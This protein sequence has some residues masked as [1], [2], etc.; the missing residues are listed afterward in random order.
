MYVLVENYLVTQDIYH[1]VVFLMDSQIVTSSGD[2]T[3]LVL[4]YYL[5]YLV[6][7]K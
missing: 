1:A 7:K 4:T 5:F 6:Y 3:W 2:M